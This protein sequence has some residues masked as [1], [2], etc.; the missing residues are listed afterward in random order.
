MLWV[1][2][3]FIC[4]EFLEEEELT[5]PGSLSCSR[6]VAAAISQYVPEDKYTLLINI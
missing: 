6:L 1:G 4:P 2:G 5:G 3:T